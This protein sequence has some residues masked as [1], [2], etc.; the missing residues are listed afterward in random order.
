[1]QVADVQDGVPDLD[2]L[3]LLTRRGRALPAG[4]L[5]VDHQDAGEVEVRVVGSLGVH[6]AC[7]LAA[8]A[9]IICRTGGINWQGG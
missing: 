9:V 5:E 3:V 4:G 2:G 7:L 8:E 6:D 1:M